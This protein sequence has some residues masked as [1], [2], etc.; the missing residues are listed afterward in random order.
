MSAPAQDLDAPVW[1]Q[2]SA[3][4]GPA[5]CAWVVARVLER[6]KA[7]SRG[8]R[9]ELLEA[10]P[11]E[12]PGTLRSALLS[13]S[14][15]DALSLAREW[16]GSI[17]WVGKSPYRPHH[18]RKNWFIG[19]ELFAPPPEQS[20]NPADFRFETTRSGGPGGQH[21]NKVE[22]AVRVTHLPTGLSV[23]ASQERSQWRNRRLGLARLLSQLQ[24]EQT[25]GREQ[26]RTDRWLAHHSLERGNPV[27][28]FRGEDFAN[29]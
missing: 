9:F 13:L 27:K 20:W 6:L 29:G 28:V 16:Q 5:E 18:R 7:A 10:E 15:P 19:V 8:L 12:Q 24:A 11:G 26:A 17:Q 14:G 22:T 23:L 4:Q 2:L 3:G 1:L 25:R 21:V